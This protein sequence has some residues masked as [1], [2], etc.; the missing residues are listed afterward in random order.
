MR[1]ILKFVSPY[2]AVALTVSLITLVLTILADSSYAVADSLNVTVLAA[3]RMSLAAVTNILP[4][5]LFEILVFLIIPIIALAVIL[6]VR[7]LRR[8]RHPVAVIVSLA[9]TVTLLLSVYQLTIGIAYDA[10]PVGNRLGI[11][12]VE[13]NEDN[14]AAVLDRLTDEINSLSESID[15]SSGHS[16]PGYTVDTISAMIAESYEKY[17]D[18]P[19]FSPSFS[20]RAKPMLL[21]PLMT[22]LELTGI[23]FP[24]TGEANVNNLYPTYDLCYTVAHEMSHQRGIM[25]EN[26]ANFMAF[27]LCY[28]S[29]DPYLRYSA[30]MNVYSYVAGALNAT[31][32]DRFLEIYSRLSDGPRADFSAS[33]AVAEQYE[34][35]LLAEISERVND[36]FL[37]SN[38]TPGVVSYGM[39]V[40]L[41]VAYLMAE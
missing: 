26:E 5:S 28:T 23:Y 13:V 20:S 4:I 18:L 8:G 3:M 38:G 24:Y 16:D 10:T 32:R 15:Y 33:R 31:N 7:R 1:K 35:E 41:A 12:E 39:V 2:A 29:G 6:T 37:K 25:R 11:T 30:A 34:N 36:W 9:A 21:S 17:A 14:L 40:R 19:G 27:L 22:S